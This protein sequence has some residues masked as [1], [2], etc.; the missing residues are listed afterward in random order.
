[1]ANRISDI[2][3]GRLIGLNE[4]RLEAMVAFW[5]KKAAQTE[6]NGQPI[7]EGAV[8]FNQHQA[9]TL[10]EILKGWKMLVESL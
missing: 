8:Q 5:D 10:R 6:Y 2:Q 3:K 1:M 9:E 4:Q 7:S